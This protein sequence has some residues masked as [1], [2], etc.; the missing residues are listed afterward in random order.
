MEGKKK[1][2]VENTVT[3]N[4]NPEMGP[5]DG[6]NAHVFLSK[7]VFE[8]EDSEKDGDESR[9]K[10]TQVKLEGNIKAS[11][12][13]GVVSFSIPE[14]GLMISARLDEVMQ[15]LFTSAGAYR[16]LHGDNAGQGGND[17]Q[18]E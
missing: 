14:E 12:E 1:S 6:A 18:E 10:F 4:D 15:V 7:T 11:Y 5:L 17:E 9:N 16:K 2:A 13:L 3:V 8:K